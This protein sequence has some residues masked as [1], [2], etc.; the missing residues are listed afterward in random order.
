MHNKEK[1]C[2]KYLNQKTFLINNFL[3]EI[4]KRN[5]NIIKEPPTD[6][7]TDYFSHYFIQDQNDMKKIWKTIRQ[8]ANVNKRFT[9]FPTMMWMIKHEK[10]IIDNRP[11]ISENSNGFLLSLVKSLKIKFLHP[12]RNFM[13]M[14]SFKMR[15]FERLKSD[16]FDQQ[17]WGFFQS[18]AFRSS[19]PEVFYKNAVLN[20]FQKFAVKHVCRKSFCKLN[21]IKNR[22]WQACFSLNFATPLL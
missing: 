20:N 1:L 5:R 15:N 7:K 11:K 9:A 10:H 22:L 13:R 3:H 12:M 2:K 19:H 16:V 6:T 18:P 14:L 17:S 21:F 4:F 8:I